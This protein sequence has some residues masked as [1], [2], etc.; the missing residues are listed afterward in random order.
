MSLL[1]YMVISSIWKH[2]E[3]CEMKHEM[4]LF[5][6][7]EPNGNV[8]IKTKDDAQDCTPM[9]HWLHDITVSSNEKIY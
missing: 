6:T 3:R 9:C 1:T 5:H 8:T 7:M 4:I 2:Y